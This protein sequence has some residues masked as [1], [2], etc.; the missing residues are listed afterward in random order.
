VG[1]VG[2]GLN[3]EAVGTSHKSFEWGVQFAAELGYEYIEPMH[4][5]DI[6]LSVECGTLDQAAR[7]I[8][9]LRKLLQR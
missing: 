8:D 1:K 3:W 4:A 2:I 5:K 9:H 7:S 6:V